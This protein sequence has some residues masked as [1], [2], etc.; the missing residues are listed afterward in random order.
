MAA[1]ARG[2]IQKYDSAKMQTHP[3]LQ[4]DQNRMQKFP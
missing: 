1:M 2:H 3:E 4:Y